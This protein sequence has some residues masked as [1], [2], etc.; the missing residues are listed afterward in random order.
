VK[1]I[2]IP[3]GKEVGIYSDIPIYKPRTPFIGPL[4]MLKRARSK[5]N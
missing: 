1:P 5:S 4:C 2:P 3:K